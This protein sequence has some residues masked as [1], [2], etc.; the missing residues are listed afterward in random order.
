MMEGVLFHYTVV[1]SFGICLQINCAVTKD[2]VN[3][4]YF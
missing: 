1:Q 4:C 2:L 3:H